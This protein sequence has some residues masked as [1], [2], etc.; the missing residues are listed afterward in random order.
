MKSFAT[1]LKMT[2]LDPYNETAKQ[3]L[4]TRAGKKVMAKIKKAIQRI[5]RELGS[6]WWRCGFRLPLSAGTA[7]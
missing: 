7:R 2:A 1:Y 6:G 3:K 5:N 4:K